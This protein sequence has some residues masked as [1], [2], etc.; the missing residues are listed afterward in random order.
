MQARP[1]NNQAVQSLIKAIEGLSADEQ[2][3]LFQFFGYDAASG[4]DFAG[5]FELT[6]D[7]VAAASG[8][9]LK[10]GEEIH[11]YKILNAFD[12]GAFTFSAKALSPNSS[13]VEINKFR[14]PGGTSP[15]FSEFVK[16]QDEIQNRIRSNPPA[17]RAC[18]ECIESFVLGKN[19]GAVT[20]RAFYEIFEYEV[21]WKSLR[22]WLT[23]NTNSQS[24]SWGE[25]L[26]LARQ[27]L[28]I[29]KCVHD[30]G[31]IH[32]DLTPDCFVFT[33]DRGLILDGFLFSTMEGIQAPWHGCEGYV[34]TPGYM[35]P[36]HIAGVAPTKASDI[37]TS[38]L[39]L[40][41]L[42]CDCNHSARV[43]E[44]IEE[45]IK[46]GKMIPVSIGSLNPLGID[47]TSLNLAL[48]AALNIDPEK[49][50]RVAD[51]ITAINQL[52]SAP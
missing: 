7:S 1:S 8:I 24:D 52:S 29:I 49:R 16:Y 13:L 34:G 19:G 22:V 43:L 5:R 23:A 35:S 25:R 9:K 46:R 41:E 3:S 38:G 20:L 10:A 37:F 18:R 32:G 51:L 39:I 11:G 33:A 30:L 44:G 50:P 17:K 31:V 28:S 27:L 2:A 15:W 6:S 45:Q 36:E 14:R 47:F 21:G 40:S 48:N 26:E 42:L 4:K 12:P